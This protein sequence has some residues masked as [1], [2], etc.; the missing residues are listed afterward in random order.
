MS[1]AIILI[2][3]FLILF[4]AIVLA[5]RNKSVTLDEYVQKRLKKGDSEEEIAKDTMNTFSK[6]MFGKPYEGTIDLDEE[7]DELKQLKGTA[8]FLLTKQ[9]HPPKIKACQGRPA[10]LFPTKPTT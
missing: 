3:I 5:R 6:S 4:T 10:S 8:T 9:P 1:V 2:A 7:I